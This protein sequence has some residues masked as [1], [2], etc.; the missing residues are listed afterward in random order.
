MI[1]EYNKIIIIKVTYNNSKIF[2]FIFKLFT[3]CSS[4]NEKDE[5]P[6]GHKS[7]IKNEDLI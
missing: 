6:F 3:F 4:L 5:K 7:Y 1:F 2:Y